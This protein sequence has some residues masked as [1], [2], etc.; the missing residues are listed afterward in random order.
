[1]PRICQ[2]CHAEIADTG[3]AIQ[4]PAC[5]G[6][7]IIPLTPDLNPSGTPPRPVDHRGILLPRRHSVG[8][9]ITPR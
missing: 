5:G 2:E 7:L 6:A 8:G 9:V 3:S 1:M 4:C